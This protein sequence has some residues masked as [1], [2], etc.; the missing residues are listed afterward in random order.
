MHLFDGY[1][2][3]GNGRQ[4]VKSPNLQQNSTIKSAT[5]KTI[6][7]KN[8]NLRVKRVPMHNKRS[9]EPFVAVFLFYVIDP[10]HLPSN[11]Q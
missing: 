3:L 11:A 5:K 8:I 1:V 6:L 7:E 4:S 9:T 2:I 10:E